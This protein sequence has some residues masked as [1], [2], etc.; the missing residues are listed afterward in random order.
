MSKF[1]VK[2]EICHFE[3]GFFE[4]CEF[5]LKFLFDTFKWFYFYFDSHIGL[6]CSFFGGEFGFHSLGCRHWLVSC[7]RFGH[8]L[9]SRFQVIFM[10]EHLKKFISQLNI[11]NLASQKHADS[12]THQMVIL[13]KRH[14][15][16]KKVEKL[17]C[18]GLNVEICFLLIKW[19]IFIRYENS[20]AVITELIHKLNC[21]HYHNFLLLRAE[22]ALFLINSWSLLILRDAKKSH[23]FLLIFD[24]CAAWSECMCYSCLLVKVIIL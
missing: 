3:D 11:G 17:I 22:I 24:F 9:L 12:R 19:L 1:I 4:C 23:I 15:F 13:R 7:D 2:I 18:D 14:F 16:L 21:F 6:L 20:R 5:W 8:L 10:I